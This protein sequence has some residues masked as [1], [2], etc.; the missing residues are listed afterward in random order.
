[1]LFRS[2]RASQLPKRFQPEES[3]ATLT[4]DELLEVSELPV[5]DTTNHAAKNDVAQADALV[6]KFS[7]L[8]NLKEGREGPLLRKS[9][10]C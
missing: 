10:G 4:V 8:K 7:T 2:S 5:T 6:A 1:M 3:G 9:A